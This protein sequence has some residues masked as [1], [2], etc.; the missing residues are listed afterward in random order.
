MADLKQVLITDIEEFDSVD[1]VEILVKEG[2]SIEVEQALL[3]IES[4]KAMMDFPSPYQGVV[5]KI[6]VTEGKQV[7]EGDVLVTLEL[8]ASDATLDQSENKATEEVETKQEAEPSV[9]AYIEKYNSANSTAKETTRAQAHNDTE[10]KTSAA[11][12]SPAVQ[13]Y[14]RELGV[15]LHSV[16]GSGRK[17]RVVESDVQQYVRTQLNSSSPALIQQK[18]LDFSAHGETDAKDLTKI[19]EVTANKMLNAWQSIPHVTHFDQADVT[20]LEKH[21]KQLANELKEKGIKLTPLAFVIKA[22]VA[23]LKQYPIFNTSLDLTLNK[24]IFKKYFHIGIAVD[25]PHGL[26]VPVIRDVDKKTITQIATELIEVSEL[27]RQ[28]KLTTKQMSGAC[29]SI[30]SLGNL[31]GQ[32]FTPIINPPEVAIVGLSKMIVKEKVTETGMEQVKFLPISLS[33]DHRVVNGADAARF[34]SH[35][36]YVLEDVWKL[37]L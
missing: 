30:S 23:T 26:L 5:H 35:L 7:K 3:T 15:D 21:R 29:M 28:R 6:N 14:A 1:V 24:L 22:L 8:Q 18:P 10:I 11:Y 33:Y 9:S 20:L 13:K 31:G 4:E 36:I 25:T 17:Q 12:A 27:A 37:I 19:Q 16:P 2:D 32:A 34:C